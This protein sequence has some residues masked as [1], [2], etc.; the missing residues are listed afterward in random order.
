ML[1]LGI[2]CLIYMITKKYFD[3]YFVKQTDYCL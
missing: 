2:K 3:I 1:W